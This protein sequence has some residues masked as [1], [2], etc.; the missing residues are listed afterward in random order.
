MPVVMY[1]GDMKFVGEETKDWWPVASQTETA[2]IPPQWATTDAEKFRSHLL[3]TQS[4]LSKVF[5]VQPRV[6][7]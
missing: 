1:A 5:P 6:G 3:E 4:Y 7:K 2:S